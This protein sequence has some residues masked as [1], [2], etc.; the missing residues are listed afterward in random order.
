MNGYSKKKS[1]HWIYSSVVFKMA[2]VEKECKH[3]T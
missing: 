1:A 2:A 3:L